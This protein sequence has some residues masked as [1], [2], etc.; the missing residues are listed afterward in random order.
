MINFANRGA[1]DYAP[2]NTKSAIYLALIQGADGIFTNLRRT[3]DGEI[4]LFCDETVDRVSDGE[5]KVSD[6]TLSQLKELRITGNCATDF[7]DTVLTLREFLENFASYPIKFVFQL[8]EESLTDDLLAM[9]AEFSI[10]KRSTVV[11]M[12]T[13]LVKAVKEANSDARVGLM[14]DL[15]E[16]N[17][18]KTVLELGGEEIFP[19]A[20]DFTEEHFAACKEA[21]LFVHVV[22]VPGKR[23]M[24][25]FVDWNVD[26]MS[27]NFPDR[28]ALFMGCG[29][30]GM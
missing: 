25:K 19:A 1:S 10:T 8:M 16:E 18:I 3:K 11:A 9:M 28:L 15:A 29:Q 23:S 21:G 13:E 7:F 30:E 27:V 17:E 5:G 24:K 22:T 12:E 20:R 6:L 4:V 14:V 26:A 2:E